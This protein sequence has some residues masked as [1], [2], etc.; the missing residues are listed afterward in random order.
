L[1]IVL[2]VSRSA[3]RGTSGMIES[4]AACFT[5]LED[6]RV[7]RRCDHQLVDILVI[8][9]CAV[10]ACAE[11]WEDIE[12]Y[13]RSKQAWLETFLAL[14]NGIPS[15]DT[16]RR[17]F[18]LLDPDA[19]EACFARWAQS[20]VVGIEREVVAIDGKTARRSGSRRH[21]HGPLHLVSA[22]PAPSAPAAAQS[23]RPQAD[24]RASRG[25]CSASARSTASRT[26]SRPSPSCSIPSGSKA[27]S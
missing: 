6:P 19:F 2:A 4:L 5:G 10:I 7:T 17:V 22:P 12:L 11:S 9:V 13:G 26:R 21:G 1:T 3:Q 27:V 16:F 23:D 25:W 14:P 15:H 18:M 8:A 24:G 20:L